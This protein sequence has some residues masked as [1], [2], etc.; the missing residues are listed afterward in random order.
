M[1]QLVALRAGLPA[2]VVVARHMYTRANTPPDANQRRSSYAYAV[3]AIDWYGEPPLRSH[4]GYPDWPTVHCPWF[5]EESLYPYMCTPAQDF[6]LVQLPVEVLSVV[7]RQL[8]L[9]EGSMQART[10]KKFCQAFRDNVF[11]KVR[12]SEKG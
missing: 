8:S 12:E 2:G 5:A 4:G 1:G 11:W 3:E 9:K 6:P 7:F 10:C